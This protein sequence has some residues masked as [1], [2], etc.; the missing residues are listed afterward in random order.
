M[1][2]V[3]QLRRALDTLAEQGDVPAELIIIDG[4][5]GGETREMMA[6]YRVDWMPLCTVVWQAAA[7]VG[8]AIQRNQGVACATQPFVL[9]FDDDI[10]FEWECL[11]QLW[12]AMESDAD[13][14]GVNAMIT[15]QK[16]HSPGIVS[17]VM[18]SLMD[19]KSRLSYAGR[20][21]GPAINLLPEDRE[22]LPAVVPVEW[23]NTACTLYRKEALPR[24]PFDS[25]FTGYSLME[26]VTVSLRVGRD[27][28][29][30]NVRG[31]RVFHDS[32]PGAHKS[33]SREVS[34]MGLVNRHYVMTEILGRTGFG[35]YCKL[36]VWEL[37]QIALTA[38]SERLR[39]PF[40]RMLHGKL[41]AI[42]V[43]VF[44][45]QKSSSHDL[46]D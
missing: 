25:V 21:L 29:L 27:W 14:G 16:Y 7:K 19:G 22:D 17:R 31:A 43:I 12:S 42:K 11:R 28:K 8:A 18:F 9:F 10:V 2:R 40:W 46:A 30:A 45:S 34:R 41:Q 44:A 23:M 39:A 32:Q 1:N 5:S 13:L 15:N 38:K 26:D 20:I 24:P 37:F 33:D 35:D 3:R 4:S 36:W 6:Q